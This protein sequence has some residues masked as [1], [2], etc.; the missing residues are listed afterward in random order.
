MSTTE[1]SGDWCAHGWTHGR[2]ASGGDDRHVGAPRLSTG[3]S[4]PTGPYP[5]CR[6]QHIKVAGKLCNGE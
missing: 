3:K 5:S 2:G 1:R 4:R 6:S